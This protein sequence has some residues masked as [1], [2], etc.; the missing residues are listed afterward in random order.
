MDGPLFLVRQPRKINVFFFFSSSRWKWHVK[1]N[2]MSLHD[3]W[4]FLPLSLNL[5]LPLFLS[6][7]V[8][9]PRHRL[10]SITLHNPTIFSPSL[11]LFLAIGK[12]KVCVCMCE[13]FCCCWIAFPC[14]HYTLRLAVICLWCG[15]T[16]CCYFAVYNITTRHS[17]GCYCFWSFEYDYICVHISRDVAWIC[18]CHTHTHTHKGAFL[19]CI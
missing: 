14:L 1:G 5:S 10:T 19:R 12:K 16:M 6:F 9:L 8:F 18:G 11:S 7:S 13:P 17:N 2:D 3:V 4:V 15:I